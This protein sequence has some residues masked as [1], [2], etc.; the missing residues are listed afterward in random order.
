M[1]C[2]KPHGFFQ[3]LFLSRSQCIYDRYELIADGRMY[4]KRTLFELLFLQT[5]GVHIC[6]S[7]DY[8]IVDRLT[9]DVNPFGW[10]ISSDVSELRM[11][12]RWERWK[13]LAKKLRGDVG[14]TQWARDTGIK[15]GKWD[16]WES[17]RKP[18]ADGFWEM[19]AAADMSIE[20][21]VAYLEGRDYA[22]VSD[23]TWPEIGREISDIDYE[24]MHSDLDSAELVRKQQILIR[25]LQSRL[26]AGK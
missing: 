13:E 11:S 18:D 17:G 8:P 2:P 6:L 24:A 1:L 10:K 7:I 4:L 23:R 16:G 5:C 22:P 20:E 26:Q 12:D 14:P 9:E 19:A 21:L 3:S 25:I 15:R